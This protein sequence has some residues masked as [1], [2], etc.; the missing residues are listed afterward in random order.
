MLSLA[1]VDG[2]IAKSSQSSCENVISHGDL[3]SVLEFCSL[4]GNL[5]IIK[6]SRIR[7]HT[8]P[9]NLRFLGC[10]QTWLC[11]Q[12]ARSG[13]TASQILKT[14]SLCICKVKEKTLITR[15]WRSLHP[16]S[17]MPTNTISSKD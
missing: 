16:Y 10:T 15:M 9:L 12:E 11:R 17:M 5:H 14:L 3:F 7:S 13:P 4:E 8:R 2:A 6:N 1:T